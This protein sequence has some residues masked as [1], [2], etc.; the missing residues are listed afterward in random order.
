MNLQKC[1]RC[2]KLITDDK[3][4]NQDGLLCETCYN[5]AV[6]ELFSVRRIGNHTGRVSKDGGALRL[7]LSFEKKPVS[8]LKT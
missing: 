2:G 4:G 1:N 5:I 7:R 8:P 6:K 3:Y